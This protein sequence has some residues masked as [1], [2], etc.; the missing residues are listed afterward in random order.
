[1]VTAQGVGVV[2]PPQDPGA[3]ADALVCMADARAAT[4]E[5]GRRGRDFAQREFLQKTLAQRCVSVMESAAAGVSPQLGEVEHR[6]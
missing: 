3:F 1:M 2:V 6:G 5:M 4:V